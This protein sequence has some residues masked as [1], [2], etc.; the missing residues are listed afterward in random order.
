MSLHLSDACAEC[1]FC[2]VQGEKLIKVDFTFPCQVSFNINSTGLTEMQ[3]CVHYHKTNTIGL[4]L[5]QYY[6]Q[7]TEL[8]KPP[9]F[10][11]HL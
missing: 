4:I 9:T 8:V 3:Q 2:L 6:N 10:N 5:D 11:P 1:A 7:S